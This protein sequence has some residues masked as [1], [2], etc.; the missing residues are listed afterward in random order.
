MSQASRQG[1]YFFHI[2]AKKK[3][4]VPLP[5]RVVEAQIKIYATCPLE[6][7]QLAEKRAMEVF[8]KWDKI[9]VR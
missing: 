7:K 8:S 1:L 6:A 2:I 9:H 4:P 5:P 3:E